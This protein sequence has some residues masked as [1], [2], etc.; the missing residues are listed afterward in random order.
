MLHSRSAFV[1]TIL[2]CIGQLYAQ[3]YIEKSTQCNA[4]IE[5]GDYQTA[6]AVCEEAKQLSWNQETDDTTHIYSAIQAG[7]A[8]YYAGRY[9]EAELNYKQ[10]HDWCKLHSSDQALLFDIVNGLINVTSFT[11]NLELQFQ[12]ATDAIA[13]SQQV[14]GYPNEYLVNIYQK[15]SAYYSGKGDFNASDRYL[16][17]AFTVYDDL[18]FGHD[19]GY[20]N[21]LVFRAGNLFSVGKYSA[22]VESANAA[23]NI[24]D[25]Y[26]GYSS[27]IISTLAL[28]AQCYFSNADYEASMNTALEGV[29]YLDSLESTEEIMSNALMFAL[30]VVNL[31]LKAGTNVADETGLLDALRYG[32]G[33]FDTMPYSDP[34]NLVNA[35]IGI[36]NYYIQKMEWDSVQKYYSIALNNT[37]KYFGKGDI[38]YMYCLTVLANCAEK[39]N[40]LPGAKD[41]YFEIIDYSVNF[42]NSNFLFVSETEKEYLLGEFTSTHNNFLFFLKQYHALFPDLPLVAAQ[43]DLFLRGLLLKNITGMRNNFLQFGSADDVQ[44]F[45]EWLRIR[46][47]AA[48]VSAQSPMLAQQMELQAEQMEKQFPDTLKSILRSTH[49]V[50]W[51]SVAD[52]LQPDEAIIQF[53]DIDNTVETGYLVKDY[54]ALVT[55]PSSDKPEY[56]YLFSSNDINPILQRG[57]DENDRSYIQRLYGFPDPDFPDDTLYFQGDKL[58]R[59]MWQPLEKYLQKTKTIYYTA[60]GVFNQIALHALPLDRNTCIFNRYNLILT[61]NAGERFAEN[62]TS[63]SSVLLAGGI[64]YESAAAVSDAEYFALAATDSITDRGG[65]WNALPG[66]LAEVENIAANASANHMQTT[67]LKGSNATESMI[68]SDAGNYDIIHIATHGYFFADAENLSEATNTPGYIYRYSKN[69]LM[70][71]GIILAGGNNTWKNGIRDSTQEDGI[72]TAYE[73][74]NLNLLHTQLVVLSACETGLGDIQGTEGVYGLQRAFR[75]AGVKQLL[76]SLWKIPDQYTAEFMQIFYNA[77]LSGDDAQTSLYKTRIAM[78]KKTDAYNWAAF[79]LVQ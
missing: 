39:L 72:L 20:A 66:T 67:T 63:F 4:L 54:V 62:N 33:Y 64:N 59:L 16:N 43:T 68:K 35:A 53:I 27:Y 15:I 74:S 79:E 49:S 76:V 6:C 56:I 8:Y 32:I 9:Q 61:A 51:K 38:I 34:Y 26:T 57:A 37:L 3:S 24:Y 45:N 73:I 31:D 22:C 5:T 2:F 69:P 78:Q 50:N 19:A 77:L 75:M 29:Q 23:I 28:E 1:L 11:N 48:S 18:G 12:M 65:L 30:L 14:Y 7:N 55:L 42:L 10:A 36:G 44:A 46:Q 47:Q 25:N 13:L 52:N 40:D 21:L 41:I 17:N 71:S 58:Y 70:R 60:A